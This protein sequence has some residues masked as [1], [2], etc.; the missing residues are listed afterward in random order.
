MEATMKL[1]LSLLLTLFAANSYCNE[2]WNAKLLKASEEGAIKLAI[3]ALD[4]GANIDTKD[5]YGQ[6]PLM[7]AA[8]NGHT[9][10][11]NL[12]LENGADINA[13]DKVKRLNVW[14][15]RSKPE[16]D[17]IFGNDTALMK[18]ASKGYKEIVKMLIKNGANTMAKNA[19]GLTALDIARENNQTEIVYLLEK[20]KLNNKENF[21]ALTHHIYRDMVLNS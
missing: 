16:E 6:T 11:V 5:L 4:N 7:L 20:N 13:K 9:I 21:F 1:K 2:V 8:N 15:G 18:A 14:C 19:K 17:I 10:M 3:H 12:L